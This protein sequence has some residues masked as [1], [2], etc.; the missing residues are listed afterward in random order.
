MGDEELN[1]I[2]MDSYIRKSPGKRFKSYTIGVIFTLIIIGCIFFIGTIG[3]DFFALL[4]FLLI[5]SIP[6]LILFRKKLL[7]ILPD[8]LS[9]SLLEIDNEEKNESLNPKFS[10]SKWVKEAGI[11]ITIVLLVITSIILLIDFRKKLNEKKTLYKILGGLLC[12]VFSG[13]LLLDI[14]EIT[15]EN[16]T[17]IKQS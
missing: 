15:T 8:F 3:S 4:I 1:D 16:T 11:Y 5:I 7:N 12:V 6:I 2:T 14:E 17:D 10:I 13:M 9:S